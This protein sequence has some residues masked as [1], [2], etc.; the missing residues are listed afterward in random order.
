MFEVFF[1]LSEKAV[2]L[3]K[4]VYLYICRYTYIGAAALG[5]M[6]PLS[7]G[8]LGLGCLGSSSAEE[9]LRSCWAVSGHLA[10]LIICMVILSFFF[11]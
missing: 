3:A 6:K 11:C 9:D 2:Q 7:H 5:R 4:Y 8:R 1:F 10:H